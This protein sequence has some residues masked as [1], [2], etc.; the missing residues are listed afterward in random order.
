[1]VTPAGLADIAKYADGIGPWK[2]QFVGVK[3]VDRNGDGKADDVNG[4]GTVNEADGVTEVFS[5]LIADAH[6]A[7]LVVHAYTFRDDVA[8]PRDFAGDPG[9]EYR[10][11]FALGLDGVFSDFPDTAYKAR[12]ALAAGRS[13]PSSTRSRE[14]SAIF[15]RPRSSSRRRSAGAS[16]VHGRRPRMRSR[17]GSPRPIGRARSRSVASIIPRPDAI[18]IRSSP[19]NARRFAPRRVR[20]TKALRSTRCG[21]DRRTV[22]RAPYRSTA[23]A[24]RST[25]SSTSGTSRRPQP[26][27]PSSPQGGRAW[28][29]VSARGLS[30]T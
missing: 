5:T 2:R 4:D 20:S 8:V 30:G 1:M 12:E 27:P 7:G 6:R 9:Q 15:A 18:S 16:S 17:S 22:R 11:L 24:S 25:T 19:P 29:S 14:R 13:P 28:A 3:G 23:C 26:R 21:V 10:Q